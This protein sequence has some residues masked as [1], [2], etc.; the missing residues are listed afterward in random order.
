MRLELPAGSR[1][2]GS[3]GTWNVARDV[4]GATLWMHEVGLLKAALTD[5]EFKLFQQELRTKMHNA[6]LGACSFGSGPEFDVDFMECTTDVL[7]LRLDTRTGEDDEAL[8]TRLYFTE[9][10]EMPGVMLILKLAWK[11]PGPEGLPEQTQ[12]AQEASMR[13]VRHAEWFGHQPG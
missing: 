10:V 12:H 8:M 5:V 6:E 1:S 2:C 4:R 9:P 3:G 7:E 13:A 11:R